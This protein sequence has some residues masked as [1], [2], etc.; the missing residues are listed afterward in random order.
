MSNNFNLK[1]YLELLGKQ[2]LTETDELQLL[3]YG[4]L[5]ERQISYNRKDEYFSLIR[6][7]QYL[8]KKINP[9]TFRGKFL[10]MQKADDDTTQIIKE[11][12]EQLSNLSIDLELEEGPFSLLIDLIYDNSM[13]A[14]EFGPEDGISE[15]EFRAEIFV[16]FSPLKLSD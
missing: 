2:D 15:D 7:R 11:D 5:V 3:W 14:V 1:H 9:S 10:E 16:Y 13:L 12:F 4:A 8:A 6:Q